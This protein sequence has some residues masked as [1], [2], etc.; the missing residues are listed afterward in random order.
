MESW[1]ARARWRALERVVEVGQVPLLR[2]LLATAVAYLFCLGLFS[3]LVASQHASPLGVYGAL[4]HSA[5]FSTGSISQ[6]LLRAVPLVLAGLAVAVPARAGLINVGGEGQLTVG[7]IAAAGVALFVLGHTAPG[8]LAWVAMGAAAVGA[9]ALWAGLAGWLRFGFGANEAVVTLLMNFVANDLLLYLLYQP[10]KDPTGSGQPQTEPLPAAQALPK[11][12][13]SN[14]NAGVLVTGVV[15]VGVILAMRR[16]GWAFSLRVVGSNREAA[17]RAGL[18]VGWLMVS[19]MAVGGGLAGLGGMLYYA[20]TQLQLLPGGTA[21][22]GYTAFLAAY[23]GRNEPLW[24]TVAAL[25]FAAVAISAPGLQLEYGVDGN[26][27]Y[28]LLALITAAP[29]ALSKTW[30]RSD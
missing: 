18:P 4:V 19:A 14:I 29:L 16:T 5:F 24:V 30:R 9:G 1:S 10:W 3:A 26:A 21:L 17:R 12:F 8:P 7:A 23:L 11:L 6:L 27:V 25:L 28:V 22:F 15:A 20:G 13:G 2:R